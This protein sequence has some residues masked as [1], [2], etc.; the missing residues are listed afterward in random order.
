MIASFFYKLFE[1]SRLLS[2][3][4]LLWRSFCCRAAATSQHVDDATKRWYRG[5]SRAEWLRRPLVRA[6]RCGP[7]WPQE[8][9]ATIVAPAAAAAWWAPRAYAADAGLL[10]RW[11]VQH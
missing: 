5:E 3:R 6:L 7:C 11:A 2:V 4:P 1:L 10:L 8:P 9:R